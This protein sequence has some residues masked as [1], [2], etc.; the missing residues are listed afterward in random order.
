MIT[1]KT[2]TN[3]DASTFVVL[4]GQELKQASGSTDNIIGI[5]DSINALSGDVCDVLEIGTKGQVVAGGTFSAGDALTADSKGRAIKATTGDNI[6]AIAYESS[7]AEN[8]IVTVVV[9]L[10]RTIAQ[11]TQN[12]DTI[13]G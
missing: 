5:S 11:E 7:T 13:G 10:C 4:D 9:A 12:N 6:G 2:K 8:Q 1:F 3:I